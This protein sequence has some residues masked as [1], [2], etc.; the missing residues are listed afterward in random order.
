MVAQYGRLLM[1]TSDDV[2]SPAKCMQFATVRT[3]L[4]M[5]TKRCVT[6][7]SGIDLVYLGLCAKL[8][9]CLIITLCEGI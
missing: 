8:L 2:C 5:I 7:S 3:V 9:C 4:A 6:V 1:D